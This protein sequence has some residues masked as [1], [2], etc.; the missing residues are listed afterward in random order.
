YRQVDRDQAAVS[1]QNP[2]GGR[3]LKKKMH[4]VKSMGRRLEREEA[5][6]T[7]RP[8]EEEA[9][10]AKFRP[11]ARIP[12][13]KRVLEFEEPE[14]RAGDR[15]LAR[16]LKLLITGGEKV[17]IVGKNG[18]GK[19]TLLRRI[20][21]DALS[22]RDIRAAYMPQ[23]YRELLGA[24]L[25]PVAFLAKTGEKEEITRLRTYLGGM[26]YTADEMARPV[27]ELS[28]GQRAKLI[29][30]KMMEDGA[31]FLI[32]DEPTRNL[33]PLSG[34]VISALLRDFPG[35]ILMT[36][37]DRAF[38]EEVPDRIL[39]LREDGLHEG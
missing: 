11:E 9:I 17:A 5:E 3:L 19:T 39:V 31:N 36:S 32:L 18:A 38:L 14:L 7:A 2:S 28:G 26:R 22:R 33:S 29:L 6:L 24:D 35:A 12:A 10:I 37:H 16:D 20:A 25:D 27:S 34:P 4:A 1:R 8:E 13:G 30:L 21:R 23:D 15:L